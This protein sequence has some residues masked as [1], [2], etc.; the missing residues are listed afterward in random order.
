[1]LVV[2]DNPE[3]LEAARVLAEELGMTT[4]T[5]GGAEEALRILRSTGGID[6]L[7]SDVMMPGISGIELTERARKEFPA[8]RMVLMTGYS[9][10]LDQGH[11]LPCT[12]IP[13]PFGRA[14]LEDAFLLEERGRDAEIVHLY[15]KPAQHL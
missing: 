15:P 3:T 13:K 1:V 2:D 5:A 7:L 11:V 14:E 8:L 9:E 6:G 10:K 12:V 4:V